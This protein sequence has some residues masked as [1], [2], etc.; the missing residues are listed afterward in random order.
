[1]LLRNVRRKARDGSFTLL[2]SPLGLPAQKGPIVPLQQEA[3]QEK[4]P[5]NPAFK[6]RACAHLF[7]S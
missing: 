2:G 4:G 6:W 1:M 5:K 7:I 3:L